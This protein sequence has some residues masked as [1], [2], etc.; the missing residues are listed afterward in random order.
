M[1]TCGSYQIQH[2][3]TL[4]FFKQNTDICPANNPTILFTLTKICEAKL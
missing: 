1:K 4:Q 2:N 3:L